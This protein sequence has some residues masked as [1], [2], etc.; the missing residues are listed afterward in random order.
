MNTH[1]VQGTGNAC[2]WREVRNSAVNGRETQASQA[3]R[4]WRHIFFEGVDAEGYGEFFQMRTGVAP[5][6]G[7]V[8][9]R[10]WSVE[11]TSVLTELELPPSALHPPPSRQPSTSCQVAAGCLGGRPQAAAQQWWCRPGN[12]SEL[13]GLPLSMGESWEDPSEGEKQ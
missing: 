10:A 1:S 2:A 7:P 3:Q 11:W 6:S 8:R 4:K 5:A 12:G 9:T 13:E